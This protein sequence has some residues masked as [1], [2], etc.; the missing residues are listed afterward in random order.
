ML[1]LSVEKALFVTV[2]PAQNHDDHQQRKPLSSNNEEV[3][4]YNTIKRIQNF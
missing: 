4:M 1:L 2:T 3:R